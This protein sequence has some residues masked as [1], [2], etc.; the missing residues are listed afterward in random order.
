LKKKHLEVRREC[1]SQLMKT[2]NDINII[3]ELERHIFLFYELIEDSY[4]SD[5]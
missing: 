3:W 1:V 5:L 2:C 4:S